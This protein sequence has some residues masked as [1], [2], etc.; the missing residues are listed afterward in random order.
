[1]RNYSVDNVLSYSYGTWLYHPGSDKKHL[2]LFA[3]RGSLLKEKE[4]RFSMAASLMLDRKPQDRIEGDEL[5]S[6]IINTKEILAH[7]YSHTLTYEDDFLI[8]GND[9][10]E[11]R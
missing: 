10:D 6:T 7:R 3:E 8:V 5:F 11:A 2:K 9:G 1:M 4:T